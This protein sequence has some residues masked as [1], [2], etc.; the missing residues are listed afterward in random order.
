MKKISVSKVIDP[1]VRCF[2]LRNNIFAHSIVKIA[3]FRKKH[4]SF[5]IYFFKKHIE[6][7]ITRQVNSF[8]HMY[9]FCAIISA[10]SD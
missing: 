9:Q 5:S 8:N 1:R 6:K 2:R 10:E 4:I 3:E 7:E